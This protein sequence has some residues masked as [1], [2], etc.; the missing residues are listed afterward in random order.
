MSRALAASECRSD[1]TEVRCPRGAAEV[2]R[3]IAARLVV[4]IAFGA[5]ACTDEPSGVSCAVDSELIC[6]SEVR[7]ST[8]D[9][10][11]AFELDPGRGVGIFVEYE[12]EGQYRVSTTCDSDYTGYSCNF[13]VLANVVEGGK[14]IDFAPEDLED[15]SLGLVADGFVNLRT[16]TDFG[17]D[18]FTLKTDP[19]AVLAIDAL[20]DCGCGNPYLF[21]I[22]DGAIHGG[23][24]S[25]VLE[26]SPSE[27]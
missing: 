5:C 14:L 20:L 27:P 26:L 25:S 16:V 4:L 12:G 9:T 11:E 15:D 18:A 2:S 23:S 21:W 10:G 19:G 24:P 1:R 17:I 8:I 3:T 13:D 7:R 22:G 6:G